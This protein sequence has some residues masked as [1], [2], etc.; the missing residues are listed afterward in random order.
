MPRA[1]S[2]DSDE[3]ETFPLHV[4]LA[5]ETNMEWKAESRC[6]GND[7]ALRRA[8]IIEADEVLVMGESTYLGSDLIAIALE[9]CKVCPAQYNCARYA[10]D[11]APSASFVFGTWG[12]D[13]TALRWLKKQDDGIAVIDEAEHAGVSVQE[14]AR[15]A[16]RGGR[17]RRTAA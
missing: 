15:T 6:R 5:F 13:Q 16:K 7:G 14:A 2:F 4:K 10:L 9:Y 17:K 11:T 1:N 8:W 3:V 12:A